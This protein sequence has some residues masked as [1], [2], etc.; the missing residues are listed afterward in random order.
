VSAL[1]TT[2]GRLIVVSGA[3]RCGKT[4]QVANQVKNERR[5]CA[6][7]PEDQWAQLPGWRKVT[8]RAE[9]LEAMH[10]K[11]HLR[12]A[13]VAGGDLKSE[14]DYWCGCVYYAGR[15]I[16]PLVIIAEELADVTTQSKAPGNWGIIIRRGLKRGITIYAISQRWSEADKTAVG[17]AS[18][19]IVFTTRPKD[20]KYVA[21]FT[22]LDVDEL[23]ALQ[24]FQF[25]QVD[26]VTHAKETGKVRF[27]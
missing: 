10:A 24:P 26:P 18:L 14:F 27:K 21:G 25:L 6:W 13:Y 12:I 9:L 17:N 5:I 11:G 19:Y 23:K 22:G 16:A 7:D 2:D 4:T 20:V 3:S 8:T 1:H 15:Y